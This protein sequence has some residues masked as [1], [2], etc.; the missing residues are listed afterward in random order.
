MEQSVFMLVTEMTQF[1]GAVKFLCFVLLGYQLFLPIHGGVLKFQINSYLDSIY[2]LSAKCLLFLKI[3]CIKV[4]T[5][6]T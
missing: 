1:L 3:L 4:L 2:M 6:S 5:F